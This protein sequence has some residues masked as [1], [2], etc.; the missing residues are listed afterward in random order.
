MLMLGM[1]RGQAVVGNLGGEMVNVAI[2]DIGGAPVQ[3]GRQHQETRPLDRGRIVV[4]ALVAT[5]VLEM[6][7]SCDFRLVAK[8]RASKKLN[9]ERPAASALRMATVFSSP[10]PTHS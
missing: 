8:K 1:A 10:L 7:L 3:P 6:S 9:G 2:A 4:P 5:G